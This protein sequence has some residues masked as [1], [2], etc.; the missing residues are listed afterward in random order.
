MNKFIT[1]FSVHMAVIL[2]LIVSIGTV[3]TL[4]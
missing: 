1:A 3:A 4:S 2:A